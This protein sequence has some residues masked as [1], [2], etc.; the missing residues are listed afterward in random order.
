[1]ICGRFTNFED[2]FGNQNW[3]SN[4]LIV[5]KQQ[6]IL[7]FHVYNVSWKYS[8]SLSSSS[9]EFAGPLYTDPDCESKERQ[10]EKRKELLQL[11]LQL[12]LSYCSQLEFDGGKVKE[13]LIKV[14]FISFLTYRV[15]RGN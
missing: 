10:V 11:L 15:I 1:M 2:A 4:I 3:V 9:P 8:P 7:V 6:K 5:V 14:F 12:P 13:F